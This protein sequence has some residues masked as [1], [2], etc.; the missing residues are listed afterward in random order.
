MD[1]SERSDAVV[2]LLSRLAELGYR[3]VTVTPDTH[4]LVLARAPERRA[5]DVRDVLGW[6]RVFSPGALPDGIFELMRA[7]GA[8]EP[9][10]GGL[11]R[12]TLRVSSVGHLLFAHSAFP[13][14]SR[15]AVFFGPDSY[16]F[17]RA[18][19]QHAPSAT[20]AVDLGCGSGVGGIVLGHF[21]SS[22]Q[23]VVLSD[24]N[25]RALLLARANAEHARVP[26][27]LVQSDLFGS[28]SGPVDLIVANPPYL[29]DPDRRAYRD[30]GAE[31]GLELSL[32]IVRESLARLDRDGGGSLLLYTGVAVVD[33]VDPFFEAIR[34][35]LRAAGARHAY[36]EIDPDIFA[37]ELARPA[38]ADAD[39]IAAVLL[40]VTLGAGAEI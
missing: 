28:I 20:R 25:D 7:A 27:E 40:R 37:S 31:H 21:G 15:D 16:R 9:L 18:I 30:G 32:R 3:F 14:L 5:G 10:P 2:A 36:D 35:D 19:R 17:A 23:P 29:V 34:E 39:R 24:I 22:A 26:A 1:E 33:G 6:S 13:T 11:W 12:P 4:A 8:C 38:Y